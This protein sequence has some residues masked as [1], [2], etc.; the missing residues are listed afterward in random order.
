MYTSSSLE[1][2]HINLQLGKRHLSWKNM[3]M[4]VKLAAEVLS[5]STADSLEYLSKIDDA[6][7]DA[8]PTISFIRNV[9]KAVSKPVPNCST[10]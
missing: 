2:C 7:K 1:T 8:G 3:K 5:S 9:S 6:F 4:K 10:H